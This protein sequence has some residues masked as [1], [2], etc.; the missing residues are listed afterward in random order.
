MTSG[1]MIMNSVSQDIFSKLAIYQEIAPM[2][3]VLQMIYIV[4]ISLIS[5][6]I[7]VYSALIITLII[8]LKHNKSVIPLLKVRILFYIHIGIYELYYIVFNYMIFIKS[9]L[10]GDLQYIGDTDILCSYYFIFIELLYFWTL[11]YHF[12]Y[13][14]DKYKTSYVLSWPFYII[15]FA[16]PALFYMFGIKAVLNIISYN[17]MLLLIVVYKA[18]YSFGWQLI[19]MYLMD[20]Y[21]KYKNNNQSRNVVLLSI[22]TFVMILVLSLMVKYNI[23]LSSNKSIWSVDYIIFKIAEILNLYYLLIIFKFI[24]AD[25][26]KRYLS[27]ISII[28]CDIIV[29]S[30]FMPFIDRMKIDYYIISPSL[31]LNSVIISIILYRFTALLLKKLFKLA[32]GA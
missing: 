17:K 27:Y 30:Y 9:H 18:F 29:I 21:K 31:L 4:V 19:M 20:K 14:S 2:L 10:Q 24:H 11:Y 16:F 23:S 13:I 6:L 26:A 12:M 15:C 28:I 5:P 1:M 32:Q 3:F 25:K 7:A 22:T 8:V